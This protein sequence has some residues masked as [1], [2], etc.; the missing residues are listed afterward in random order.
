MR[1]TLSPRAQTLLAAAD[2][3]EAHEWSYREGYFV[4]DDE[5]KNVI[6]AC[7]VGAI[8][9]ALNHGMGESW[10]QIQALIPDHGHLVGFNDA[11]GRT[12]D[13]VVA[14]LRAL[15]VLG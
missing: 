15:A 3:L 4:W 13:E 8:R 10:K 9:I 2:W 7:A 6:G 12:K 14:H 11:S 5:Y 1:Q